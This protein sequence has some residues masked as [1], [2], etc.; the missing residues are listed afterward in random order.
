MELCYLIGMVPAT[1]KKGFAHSDWTDCLL[2]SH[3]FMLQLLEKKKELS[4]R[5]SVL[6]EEARIAAGIKEEAHRL[7]QRCQQMQAANAALKKQLKPLQEGH[8][9]TKALSEQVE[10]PAVHRSY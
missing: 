8:F 3:N 4:K 2:T 7:E 10:G 9:Q 5:C 1:H 6:E